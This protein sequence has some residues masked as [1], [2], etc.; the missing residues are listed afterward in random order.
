MNNIVAFGT[1]RDRPRRFGEVAREG[2]RILFF[3]GVR[4]VRMDEDEATQC[5]AEAKRLCELAAPS[6]LAAASNARHAPG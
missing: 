3:T 5:A 4:Y 1:G 2:A 6:E